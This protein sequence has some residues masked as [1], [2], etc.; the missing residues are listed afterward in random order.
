VR[1]KPDFAAAH[2]NLGI[3]SHAQGQFD[4]AILHYSEALRLDPTDLLA[5][6]NR[7]RAKAALGRGEEAIG[8]YR[9]VLQIRPDD[10]DALTS[11]AGALASKKQIVE[12]IA[13]YRRALEVRPDTPAALVDLAWILATSDRAELRAPEEAVRLAERVAE[14]TDRRNATA[15]ETLAV[16]YFA[17]GRTREAIGATQA[18]LNLALKDGPAELADALTRRLEFYRQQLR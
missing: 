2:N 1:L 15:L 7:G 17:A 11:L 18:A 5:P 10:P 4:Q 6:Y 13:Y 16:A 3:V 14:L 12:A 8:D 9:H